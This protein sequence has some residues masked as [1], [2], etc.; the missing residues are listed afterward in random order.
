[1]KCLRLFLL[2]ALCLA[3]GVARGEAVYGYDEPAAEEVT[4][5][6]DEVIVGDEGVPGRADDGSLRLRA[7]V[8]GRLLRAQFA[9]PA[10]HIWDDYCCERHGRFGC[11][12]GCCERS[13]GCGGPF[14]KDCCERG[15]AA[16]RGC[17]CRTC[18]CRG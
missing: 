14:H 5:H 10:D 12:S 4:P 9:S 15:A 13:F 2:A 1:M 7:V 18:T 11:F 17:T 8:V 6:A 16:S 3:A